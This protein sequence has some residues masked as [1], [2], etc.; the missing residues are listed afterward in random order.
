MRTALGHGASPVRVHA[1]PKD[2]LTKACSK[3]H[4]ILVFLMKGC[5]A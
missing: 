2:V 4:K 1:A 3:A 5:G